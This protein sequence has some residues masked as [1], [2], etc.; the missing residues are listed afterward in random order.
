MSLNIYLHQDWDDND[1]DDNT[2]SV[3]EDPENCAVSE[4]FDPEVA[5]DETN[6]EKSHSGSGSFLI[7]PLTFED[8][9]ELNQDVAPSQANAKPHPHKDSEEKKHLANHYRYFS[10]RQFASAARIVPNASSEPR[11]MCLSLS[12][13][14]RIKIFIHELAIRGLLPFIEKMMRILNDQVQCFIKLLI[15]GKTKNQYYKK[16]SDTFN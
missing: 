11:G 14:D 1:L 8:E 2:K 3:E 9:P 16:F 15:I 13:H 5:M 10:S 12:D 4:D 6:N 7:G